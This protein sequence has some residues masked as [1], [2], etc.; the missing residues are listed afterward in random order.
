MTIPMTTKEF[1]LRCSAIWLNKY[2]Y[3][4]VKYEKNKKKVTIICPHHGKF[5]Q[6][7]FGHLHG[8]EGCKPCL[9]QFQVGLG[10]R[11]PL[12]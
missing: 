2:D 8:K 3:S 11:L 7:P 10:F 1:K 6:T 9:H 4:L 5:K 12:L